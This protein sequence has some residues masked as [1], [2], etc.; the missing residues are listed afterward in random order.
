MGCTGQN[1]AELFPLQKGLQ[2]P[3]DTLHQ[4]AL[5]GS[6]AIATT[7]RL[8]TLGKFLNLLSYRVPI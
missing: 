8:V 4:Q 1:P 5:L 7:Y 3:T 2:H 6:C